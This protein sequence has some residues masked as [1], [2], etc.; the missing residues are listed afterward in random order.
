M[1]ASR[2]QTEGLPAMEGEQGLEQRAFPPGL[3]GCP[4]GPGQAAE[5]SAAMVPFP[6]WP[7][8]LGSGPTVP[9]GPGHSRL[10][11]LPSFLARMSTS[12]G[13]KTPAT[14]A[15]PVLPSRAQCSPVGDQ[16]SHSP[17]LCN[18][19]L[20]LWGALAAPHA[21]LQGT[22]SRLGHHRTH[23]PIHRAGSRQETHSSKDNVSRAG[24]VPKP[25]PGE[26]RGPSLGQV[27]PQRT[28]EVMR[29]CFWGPGPV[30]TKAPRV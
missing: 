22:S 1:L 16:A 10:R 17:H 2:H 12:H 9:A 6:T 19:V 21:P 25:C 23:G 24:P 15:P 7:H 29:T 18:L 11:R 27:V 28:L 13:P 3:E 4:K 5:G 26:G 14:R 30:G 20:L 8:P